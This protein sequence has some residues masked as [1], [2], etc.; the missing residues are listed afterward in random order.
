MSQMPSKRFVAITFSILL[1]ELEL[2]VIPRPDVPA[3]V[4]ERSRP[5]RMF[6]EPPDRQIAVPGALVTAS[7]WAVLSPAA[8]VSTLPATAVPSSWAG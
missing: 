5:E 3:P 2:N 7:P 8:I 1:S 4:R 6:P